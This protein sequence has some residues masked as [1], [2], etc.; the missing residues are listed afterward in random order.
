M[1]V[2]ERIEV[3]KMFPQCMLVSVSDGRRP[4]D[5]LN[6]GGEPRSREWP[7]DWYVDQQGP[8]P[9]AGTPISVL[10]GFVSSLRGKKKGPIWLDGALNSVKDS[11]CQF[12]LQNPDSDAPWGLSRSFSKARFRI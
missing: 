8:V 11:A 3:F 4:R 2:A 12:A 7:R 10:A 6:G 1:V 5:L 9:E